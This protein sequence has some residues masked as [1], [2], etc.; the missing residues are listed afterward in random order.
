MSVSS[1][2][3]NRSPG[4]PRD[5]SAI[6]YKH[7]FAC[8][9]KMLNSSV[10]V[11]ESSPLITSSCENTGSHDRHF[12]VHRYS[13]KSVNHSNSWIFTTSDDFSHHR[14]HQQASTKEYKGR[15]TSTKEC[16]CVTLCVLVAMAL[17]CVPLTIHYVRF[18]VGESVSLS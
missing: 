12:S 8:K 10:S 18:E 6:S 14:Y 7:G 1:L 9:S 17:F 5:G 2:G 15:P 13:G 4:T 3:R 16:V 11:K